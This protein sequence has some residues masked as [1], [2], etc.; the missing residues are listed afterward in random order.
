M[1]VETKKLRNKLL[2]LARQDMRRGDLRAAHRRYQR[3]TG[4]DPDNPTFHLRFADVSA[5]LEMRSQAVEAYLRGATLFTRDAFEEKA[6]ATYRRALELDPD[7][8]DV[9]ELLA[10]VFVRLG[11]PA[12]A[13]TT[14]Q[15]AVSALEGGARSA[16]ALRLQRRIA[17]IDP[18]D[19]PARLRLAGRLEREDMHQEAV[20]EFVESIVESACQGAPERIPDAFRALVALEPP[21]ASGLS[22]LAGD[23]SDETEV[24]LDKLDACRAYHDSLEDL[25]RRVSRAYRRHVDRRGSP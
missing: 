1:A 8:V 2:R 17:E 7:R 5:R 12:D 15:A 13:I 20:C 11:R 19:V 16:I 18:G 4:L 22:K 25:Y 23:A 3:L 24:L 10:G 21:E 6:I 14:L 9:S